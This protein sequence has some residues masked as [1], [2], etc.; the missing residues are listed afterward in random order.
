M[1][2]PFP[3]WSSPSRSGAVSPRRDFGDDARQLLV[4]TSTDPTTALSDCSA[5]PSSSDHYGVD[6][7]TAWQKFRRQG[8]ASSTSSVSNLANTIIG[9]GALAFPSAFASMG[10]LPGIVSCAFSGATSGF[11]LYLLSRCATQVGRP[12]GYQVDPKRSG[13][14]SSSRSTSVD[15]NAEGERREE[16]E[17]EDDVDGEEAKLDPSTFTPAE[18]SFNTVALLTFGQGWAT[19]C[20]D[21]AIAIKC[22]GVSV[23]YLIIVKVCVFGPVSL[24]FIFYQLLYSFPDLPTTDPLVQRPSS[25]PMVDSHKPP[26]QLPTF[27]EPPIYPDPNAP[28]RTLHV[29]SL[30]R[31]DSPRI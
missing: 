28:S 23:S 16:E 21:A 4:G 15:R 30:T 7:R 11:G 29:A 20:F 17:G 10:I 31:G 19:R 14:R 5:D 6:D 25:S 22:F 18:A 13:S 12:V 26:A 2:T 27:R 9:S 1:S 24:Y 8:K 3:T